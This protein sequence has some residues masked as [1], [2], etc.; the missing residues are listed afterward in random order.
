MSAACY[1][2]GPGRRGRQRIESDDAAL[3]ASAVLK[4]LTAAE[5]RLYDYERQVEAATE[6]RFVQLRALIAEADE[7]LAATGIVRFDAATVRTAEEQLELLL[8]QAGYS[9]EQVAKLI[10]RGKESPG[11][12][13]RNAA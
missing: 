13:F 11:E 10:V 2:G 4:R 12:G 3:R 8:L 6:T 5:T 9:P 1:C 7:R